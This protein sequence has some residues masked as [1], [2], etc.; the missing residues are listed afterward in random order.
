MSSAFQSP[1][2]TQS[3]SNPRRSRHLVREGLLT[4]FAMC[5]CSVLLSLLFFAGLIVFI[6]WLS[7]RPHRPRLYLSS[8]S[9][10]AVAQPSAGLLNSPISFNVTDRNSN[11]KIGIYYDVVYGS[12]YYKERM[13]ASGPV[14]NPFFQPPKNTTQVAGNLTGTAPAAGDALA[15]QLSGEAAA[16][17]V[18]FR[19][20]LKSLIRFK[21]KTWDT[22]HHTLHVECD[23]A[24]GSDG[25]LLAAYTNEKCSIYF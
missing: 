15:A 2:Q 13:V 17:R 1:P 20:D 21:V 9:A 7:L 18:E 6:L 8:F 4:R 5:V 25:T 23:L 10:P 12:V 11:R 16:G 24:V 3:R 14:L 19:L 22:H